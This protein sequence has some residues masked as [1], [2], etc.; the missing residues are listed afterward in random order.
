MTTTW[1]R[2]S[3]PGLS[4]TGFI[5]ASGSARAA[6]AW[7]HWA[8]PISRPVGGHHRVVG[9]V[10]RLER[11]D[12]QPAPHQRAA[13][14]GRHH[15]LA[16]VGRGPQHHQ[17]PAHRAGPYAQAP[18]P[19]GRDGGLECWC[20]RP[21]AGV[22]RCSRKS[23]EIPV[24]S[25][26]C[27]AGPSDTRGPDEPGHLAR[28]RETSL[29]RSLVRA[30]AGPSGPV[31]P[32]DSRPPQTGGCCARPYLSAPSPAPVSPPCSCCWAWC[33]AAAAGST[34][35]TS[36]PRRRP[37]PPTPSSPCRC[38]PARSAVTPRSPS[39][40]SRRRSS[41]SAPPPPR[42]CG[43]SARATRWS[44]WTTSPTSRRT[45]RPPSCRATSPTSRR[46][47]STSPTW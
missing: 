4:S 8:R 30:A 42:C 46:S 11:R 21:D 1:L 32:E 7:T 2:R 43:R 44:P 31:R 26:N 20:S 22:P 47:S 23:G 5:A 6:S 18:C 29:G 13:Q 15:G 24:L 14:P 12:P 27:E 36:R 38:S 40:P 41:R 37:R 35:S 9:H 33:S 34:P 45:C 39:T 3:L 28:G 19:A 16:R 10:L 25:R 17:A